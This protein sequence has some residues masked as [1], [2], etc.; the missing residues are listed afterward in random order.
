MAQT[1]SEKML[2]ARH[3]FIVARSHPQLHEYL[4]TR[5]RD[6]PKV[7]VI[8]D[9]RSGDGRRR[10]PGDPGIDRGGPDRRTR[11][12]LDAQLT[13]RSHVIVTIDD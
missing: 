6:D 11:H 13:E 2:M 8:L 7:E 5:F 10:L 4:V 12:D 3:L 9:R 1:E